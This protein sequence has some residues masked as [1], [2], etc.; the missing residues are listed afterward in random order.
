MNTDTILAAV[1]DVSRISNEMTAL[2]EAAKE[3]RAKAVEPFLDALAASGLVSA[4]L[5]RGYT[6]GFNDGEPCEHTADIWVNIEQLAGDCILEDDDYGLDVPEELIEGLQETRRY[7]SPTRSFDDFPDAVRENTDLC[8]RFGHVWAAPPTEIMVALNQL[9]FTMEE[10]TN[11]TN[12]Y[13]TYI[14]KDG[15]FERSS[16]DY[17]CGH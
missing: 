14:L 6:P 10:E 3:A 15:K 7:N 12:Y 1:S 5:V 13:V 2:K 4:I 17:D 8:A 16:G 9:I 11:G